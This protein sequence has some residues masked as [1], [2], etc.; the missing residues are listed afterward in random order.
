MIRHKDPAVMSPAER[1]AELGA[2]LATGY[3]RYRLRQKDLADGR[4]PER[5]CDSVDSPEESIA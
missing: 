1:M 4:Q 5:A 3:R 2:L